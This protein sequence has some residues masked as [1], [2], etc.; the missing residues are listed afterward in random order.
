MPRIRTIDRHPHGEKNH[1]V[2]D[3][4]F[5]VNRVIPPSLAPPGESRDRIV[6]CMEWWKEID[7]QVRSHRAR[8]YVPDI[9]IAESFKVLAKKYYDEKWF[10]TAT[11][12][13]QAREKLRKYIC[14]P[15]KAL[16]KARRHIAV[17]DIPTTRD[18]I[19]AIDRFYELFH[20]HRFR[21]VSVPDLII[22]S[23]AKY[24]VDFYDIPRPRLHIV[25][26]DHDLRD[27]S[28]KIPELPNAYDPTRKADRAAKV[29]Q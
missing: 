28:K 13:T 8:V 18:I 3:A 21:K 15:A 10:P 19:I 11:R 2:V 20:K 25:T 22:V 14:T 29:F 9:S 24:L 16:Q 26:L 4:C 23:T 1:F 17:H 12:L 6:L 7:A 5:L 27:G